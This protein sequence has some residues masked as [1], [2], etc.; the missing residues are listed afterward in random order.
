[1]EKKVLRGNRNQCSVCKRYFNSNTA[2]DAHRTGHHGVD[3]RCM[4]EEEMM[5]VGMILRPDGFW[6]ASEMKGY[7]E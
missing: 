1:M 7:M 5:A 3:R 2:F 4:T 6:I